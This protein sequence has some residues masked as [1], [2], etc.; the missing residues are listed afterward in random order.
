MDEAKAKSSEWQRHTGDNFF[1]AAQHVAGVAL[2][3][4]PQ[5]V[6]R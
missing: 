5:G 1:E 3:I 2:P 4:E 6:K